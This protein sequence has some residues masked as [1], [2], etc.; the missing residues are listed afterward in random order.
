MSDFVAKQRPECGHK[1]LMECPLT[2]D[3]WAEVMNAWLAFRFH[4]L[5]ISERAH[6]RLARAIPKERAAQ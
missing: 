3:D 6:E 4:C 5:L 2:S 1:L